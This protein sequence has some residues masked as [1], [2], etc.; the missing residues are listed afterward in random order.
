[1]PTFWRAKAA[2]GL[3]RMA[4]SSAPRVLLLGLNYSPE[5]IGIGPYTAGLAEALAGSGFSVEVITGRPYYPRWRPFAGSS[6]F[7]RRTVEN[8]VSVMRCPHYIP[9]RPSGVKR[10]AHLASFA[11]AALPPALGAALRRSPDVVFAVAPALLSLPVAWV[12][13]RVA[14]A[15]LWLHVQ[16]FEVDAAFAT[17]LLDGGSQ[18][19][20]LAYGLERRLLASADMVSTISPQMCE[21]LAEK[22]V[23]AERIHELRN[24]AN[25]RPSGGGGNG[26]VYRREWRLGDRKVALYSGNIG[27]KQGL[28][29]VI[30]A[31]RVLAGR[32]DIVFVICGNGPNRGRLE[33]LAQGLPNMLFQDL[34]PAGR[35]DDL[36]A[37]AHVHL[38]PQIADA[39]DLVLPSKLSNMLASGR[40]VAATAREGTGLAREVEGCGIVTPP[41]DV[42]ALAGAVAML[43]DA[44]EMAAGLGRAGAVRAQERWSQE[45]IVHQFARRLHS[46]IDRRESK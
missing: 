45:A 38:L 5:E 13:A 44:P 33:A 20:A 12:A 14:G 15:R 6:A 9:A 23:A 37:L 16:D 42:A 31:A 32:D 27:N 35:V 11:A 29:L 18:V 30:D 34:Q 3:A 19:A 40:P 21:K 36:L 8:G 7:W 41:G 22:G 24:W 26:D 39:A 43:A 2:V 1:M 17:G 25:H 10:M 46:T 28:E 4:D